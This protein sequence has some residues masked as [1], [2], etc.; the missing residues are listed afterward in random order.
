MPDGT[1]LPYRDWLPAGKPRAVV[2]ALHG[3]NDSRDAWEDPGPD[4]AAAGI[5]VFAPD[6]RG[7]GDTA[8]A[9]LLARHRALVDDA[10][11]M[12]RLLRRAAI[13]RSQAD[14]DGREHGRRGADVPR[15]AR[16]IRRRS[17]A[18]CWSSPAVWGRAEM[19]V[20][21]R[22]GLWLWIATVPGLQL[23]GRDREGHGERQPRGDD[24]PVDRPA[25]DPRDPRGR[26]QGPGRSD[27]RGA[28]RAPRISRG[29]ALFLYGGKDELI[30]EARR[31]RPR[32][33]RCRRSARARSIR[34][35]TI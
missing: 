21:E 29:P 17:T 8:G 33:G 2:L 3:M 16:P 15:R 7:F 23:T 18:T 32:G 30:P 25:D 4:F 1:R 11:T 14:P 9:R 28:G 24:A 34:T 35:A 6:Q 20:F 22:G 27:G 10:R 12:A 26:D 13:P 19:N 5:A 31:P